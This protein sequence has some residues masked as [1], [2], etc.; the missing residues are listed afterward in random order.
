MNTTTMD[1]QHTVNL[2]SR[3]PAGPREYAGTGRPPP[4]ATPPANQNQNYGHTDGHTNGHI[5]GHAGAHTDGHA[6]GH[7]SDHTSSHSSSHANG[8]TGRRGILGRKQRNRKAG[9]PKSEN[10]LNV[11]FES[12]APTLGLGN[13][14]TLGHGD[15]PMAPGNFSTN[16]APPPINR[17][18]PMLM[19]NRDL[20]GPLSMNRLDGFG[21]LHR[22]DDISAYLAEYSDTLFGR[23]TIMTKVVPSR[24][25]ACGRSALWVWMGGNF[26][27]VID[28]ISGSHFRSMAY[29]RPIK[30]YDRCVPE[31]QMST[32]AGLKVTSP[33]RTA[34]DIALMSGTAVPDKRRVELVCALMQEYHIDP[35]VCLEIL[36]KNHF[37]PNMPQARKFFKA[38][39]Y[40]F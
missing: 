36:Q 16:T 6:K 27:D 14:P 5:T 11:R 7:D 8:H 34:C 38:V 33:T 23:G 21:A 15:A 26:P 29:G 1:T 13:T 2:Y 40:C 30:T 17:T 20:P 4:N 35:S 9:S 25:I 19:S 37:W 28:I 10:G 32:I 39:Q 31:G 12:N 24:S 3:K 18:T 22:L